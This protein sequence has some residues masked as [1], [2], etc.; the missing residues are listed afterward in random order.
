MTE[1]VEL[2]VAS[3]VIPTALAFRNPALFAK[4]IDTIDEI[5]E[6]RVILGL[7]AG[8]PRPEF[9]MFGFPTDH[10]V[11]RF[12]EAVHIITALLRDGKID[13]DGTYYQMRNCELRPRGPR[14]NGPPVMI[15]ARGPRMMRLA[16]RYADYWNWQHTLRSQSSSG[17]K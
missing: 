12:E 10:H 8:N 5:S 7:G 4:L 11:S 1:T 17:A 15:G 6:G 16:A 2:D 9:S 13:F 14:P 3:A